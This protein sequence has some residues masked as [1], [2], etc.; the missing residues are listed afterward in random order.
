MHEKADIT[1]VK[2]VL[3]I[4]KEVKNMEKTEKTKWADYIISGVRY[5][6]PKTHIVSVEVHKD[7]GDSI[8][9]AVQIVPKVT[10][11]QNIDNGITYMTITKDASNPNKW[12]KGQIVRVVAG[13]KYIRTDED[14]RTKDNLSS[15]PEF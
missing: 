8:D 12:T 2:E 1:S 6:E 3:I 9:T 11:I 5:N 14:A 15:L 13:P 10:V 7:L 4:N